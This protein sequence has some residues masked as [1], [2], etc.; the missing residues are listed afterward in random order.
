[1]KLCTP[2]QTG[3]VLAPLSQRQHATSGQLPRCAA[4]FLPVRCCLTLP[5]VAA[6]RSS[7]VVQPYCIGSMSGEPSRMAST[8]EAMDSTYWMAA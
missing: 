8:R 4:A 7:S 6:D 5:L 2:Q 1:M 3:N